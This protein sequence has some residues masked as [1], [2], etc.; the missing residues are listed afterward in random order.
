[1]WDIEYKPNSNAQEWTVLDLYDNKTSA[2][3]EASRISDD[4]FMLKVTEP[5][6]S[7]IWC[8]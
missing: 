7:L 6:G 8:K 5:D 4:Y 3:I 2:C 1:M